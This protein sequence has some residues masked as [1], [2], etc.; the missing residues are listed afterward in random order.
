MIATATSEAMKTRKSMIQFG[1]PEIEFV[2]PIFRGDS[3]SGLLSVL[4]TFDWGE[5]KA[6]SYGWQTWF[7][8]ATAGPNRSQ[9]NSIPIRSLPVCYKLSN[10]TGYPE[11]R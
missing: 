2:A 7:N 10:I 6:R 8:D 11:Q 3:L 1:F 4:S 5:D 9:A